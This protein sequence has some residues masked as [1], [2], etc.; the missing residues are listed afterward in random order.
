MLQDVHTAHCCQRH[1]CCYGHSD[2][3]VVLRGGQEGMCI[4]CS[5]EIY[6][7][8]GWEHAHEL[9]KMYNLAYKRGYQ[10]LAREWMNAL[11]EF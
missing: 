4:Q 6:D 1:G 11:E 5:E 3:T 2:C 8:G 9:N 7:Y 10:R